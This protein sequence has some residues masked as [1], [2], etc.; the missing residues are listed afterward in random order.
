MR[1]QSVEKRAPYQ[2]S[3]RRTLHA[4]L[5]NKTFAA[6]AAVSEREHERFVHVV[7]A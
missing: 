5:I 3:A 4:T 7:L 2:L 1:C 6:A